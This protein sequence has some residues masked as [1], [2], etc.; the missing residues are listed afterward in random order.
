MP[1]R[2]PE[3]RSHVLRSPLALAW[4]WLAVALPAA[5]EEILVDGIAAQVGDQVVLASEIEELARPTLERM[6][7]AGVPE[8]QALQLRKDALE[9]LIEDRLIETVVRRLELTATKTEIDA[10]I[11]SIA[12]DTGLSLGQLADSVSGYGMTFEEYRD[13]IKSEIEEFMPGCAA[14]LAAADEGPR[15]VQGR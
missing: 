13:K 10:A 8:E 7:E 11:R 1:T 15:Q 12:D 4:L 6:R 5:A 3:T 2:R 9:R 14:P